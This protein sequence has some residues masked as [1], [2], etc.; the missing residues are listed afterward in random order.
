MHFASLMTSSKPM[1]WQRVT[2]ASDDRISKLCDKFQP[3]SF[4]SGLAALTISL[5]DLD[6]PGRAAVRFVVQYPFIY[7]LTIDFK[8]ET[9][10]TFFL[11]Q[12]SPAQP[13][14]SFRYR[15]GRTVGSLV[16]MKPKKYSSV[17][18]IIPQISFSVTSLRRSL[19]STVILMVLRKTP[20]IYAKLLCFGGWSRVK[21]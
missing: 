12:I 11:M 3:W 18:L 8:I 17:L 14:T 4:L 21:L 19:P 13:C 20:L 7:N 2:N 9:A 10:V 5:P 16:S 1:T 15:M 6:Q